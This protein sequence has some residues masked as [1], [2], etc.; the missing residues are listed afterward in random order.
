MDRT[1]ILAVLN[2]G[3]FT[4]LEGAAEGSDVDFKGAPYQLEQE[5]E[6]Y[7]LAKDVAAL[8]NAAGGVIVIGVQTKLAPSSNA[9]IAVSCSAMPSDLVD[10]KQMRH[11]ACARVYPQPLGLDVR[12]HPSAEDASRGLVSVDVPPQPEGK[13]PF[14]VAGPDRKSTRLNSSHESVSRMPSSA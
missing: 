3:N 8:A 1:A 7:E 14:L 9:E 12:F 5:R 11:I 6:K 10:L 13:R 4:P 2:S